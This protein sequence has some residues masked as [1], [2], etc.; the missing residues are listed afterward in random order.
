MDGVIGGKGWPGVEGSH[1]ASKGH[2]KEDEFFCESGS[3]FFPGESC[4]P[5]DA[6]C[7]HISNCKFGED[8]K[9]CNTYHEKGTFY[10][11]WG[12]YPYYQEGSLNYIFDE[13]ECD[14]VDDCYY[15]AD[16]SDCHNKRGLKGEY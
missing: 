14:G 5:G 1:D 6:V 4:V 7:N 11:S 8:E 12:V 15:K 10:C 2:C 16:E 3:N 13:Y 9:D